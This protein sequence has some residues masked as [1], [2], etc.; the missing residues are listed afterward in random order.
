MLCTPAVAVEFVILKNGD[1]VTGDVKRIWNGDV[2]VEPD[3]GDEYAIDLAYVAYVQSEEEVEVEVRIGRRIE[4]VTGRLGQTESGEAGVIADTGELVY[5][6]ALID[7]ASEIEDFF[8]WSTRTDL[9]VNVSEGNTDT[10]SS[11]LSAYGD[12]TL[13]DHH[14]EANFTRDEQR[15]DDELTKD[16]TQISFQDSWTFTDDWFVRGSVSWTSDPIRQLDSRTR[17]F[18]GPGYHFYDDSKRTLNMSIGPEW[19]DENIGGEKDSSVAMKVSL[20]YEQH[21]MDDDLVVFQ[22]SAYT[23]IF[24]GRENEISSITLGFRYDIT[25]DIYANLQGTYDYESN[26]AEDQQNEDITYLMGIG[27]ELD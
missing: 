23:N 20:D 24:E 14:F 1:R 16:Q 17:V 26:P 5:P 13:G 6:L 9:S 7:N 8:D 3:Y 15:T 10:S 11:R 19:V 22:N 27:I 25:D 2:F 12:V 18:V 4:K 21:F